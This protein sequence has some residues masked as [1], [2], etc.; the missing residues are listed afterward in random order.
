MLDPVTRR[1]FLVT[2]IGFSGLI[3]QLGPTVFGIAKA[4]AQ[5]GSQIDQGTRKAM[6]R[7]A[8]LLYPHAAIPDA[9]YGEALDQ[10]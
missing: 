2:A 10:A 8:R 3:T 9:V 7:M 4:F 5:S 6:V 1:R